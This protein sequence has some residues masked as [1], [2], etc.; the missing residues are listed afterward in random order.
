[1]VVIYI[2]VGLVIVALVIVLI[3]L[4]KSGKCS[5]EKGEENPNSV[6]ILNRDSDIK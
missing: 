3:I 4:Y 5:R 6:S 1:M 2:V